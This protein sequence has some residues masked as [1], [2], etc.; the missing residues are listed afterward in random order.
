MAALLA[1]CPLWIT[2]ASPR[3]VTS[4]K[5]LVSLLGTLYQLEA[6]NERL[7]LK[8]RSIAGSGWG[9]TLQPTATN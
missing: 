7:K 6:S 8:V 3:D 4:S 1:S 5:T 2:L 9:V